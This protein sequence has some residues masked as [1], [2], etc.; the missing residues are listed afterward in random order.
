MG[1]PLVAERRLAQSPFLN[2][3]S[4]LMR[5]NVLRL[6]RAP[7]KAYPIVTRCLRMPCLHAPNGFCFAVGHGKFYL[8][9]PYNS[10]VV[11]AQTRAY[12]GESV[13]ARRAYIVGVG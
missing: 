10:A 4:P 8:S 1:T 11:N 12:C 6:P 2:Q 3:G 13:T 7:I 9:V 5:H